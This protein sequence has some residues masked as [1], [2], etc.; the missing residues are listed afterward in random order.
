M[1]EVEQMRVLIVADTD[2]DIKKACKSFESLLKGTDYYSDDTFDTVV[3]TVN[4]P[5]D[6]VEQWCA[7]SKASGLVQNAQV[8]DD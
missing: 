2:E 5:R 6:R 3:Y 7:T 8:L 4:V 1:N